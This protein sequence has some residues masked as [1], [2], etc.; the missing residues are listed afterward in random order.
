MAS[1]QSSQQRIGD[2]YV[3][4]VLPALAAR[5]DTAFPEFGWKQDARGWVA[6]NEEMT[7]RVLGVRAE[8]VVAHGSAPPG[9]PRPRRGAH[10]LDGVPQRWSRSARRD[11]PR[12]SSRSSRR[13][14]AWTPRRSSGR[15]REI[16]ASDLLRRLLHAL[17]G[18]AAQRDGR[19]SARSYLERRGFPPRDRS[20]RSR[21]RPGRA[22]HQ[23]RARS[24]RLLRAR[25][26]AVR[27]ARRRPLAR[28][29]LRSLARRARQNRHPLGTLASRL[30]LLDSLPLP[31]RREPLGPAA[32]RPCR[33]VLR[34]AADRPTRARSGRGADRRPPPP[35]RG[36]PDCCRCR[37]RARSARLWS[38]D[39]GD[40][41]STR[42]CSP[43]TTTRRTRR[44]LASR[45]RDEPR[46]ERR[47]AYAFSS[48]TRSATRR[49][50]TR[51][52][53]SM[54]SNVP[55]SRRPGRVRRSPGARSN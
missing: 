54:G 22:L 24:S 13:E 38:P 55:R 12:R 33:S 19:R 26:R 21:S 2:F 11:I 23:E 42:S 27:R 52:F 49:I 47:R 14:Q 36:L 17:P 15:S 29:A 50:P 34:S 37:R 6:T 10:A 53:G 1:S 3:E 39:S 40:S 41:A 8:R 9:F 31:P 16:A 30:R 35:G 4:V 46:D 43:S 7:H 25:D 45:R 32:L 51:S 48:P 44:H 20:R 5:L 18:R 28:A